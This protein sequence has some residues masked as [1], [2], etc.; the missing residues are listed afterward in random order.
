MASDGKIRPWREIAEE[1]QQERDPHRIVELAR[2]LTAALDAEK[3]SQP[4]SPGDPGS[5]VRPKAD[6]L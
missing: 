6:H 4:P 5:I 1:L 3:G 2:E